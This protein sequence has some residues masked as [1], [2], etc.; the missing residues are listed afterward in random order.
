MSTSS[1]SREN[2]VELLIETVPQFLVQF[3]GLVNLNDDPRYMILRK[4][5]RR[6]LDLQNAELAGELNPDDEQ[7]LQNYYRFLN[8]ALDISECKHV[9]EI[10]ALAFFE[11]L[12]ADLKLISLV[13]R[14]LNPRAK[15][16][17]TEV[18]A[19]REEDKEDWSADY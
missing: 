5:A 19:L 10:L 2:I 7:E 9:D 11:N 3:G 13:K 15:R 1:L 18:I 8:S 4:A 6:F 12:P 17:C 16:L 14:R